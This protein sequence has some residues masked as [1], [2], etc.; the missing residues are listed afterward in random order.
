MSWSHPFPI[1]HIFLG[2]FIYLI[3]PF[4]KEIS[5]L[6]FLSRL[7]IV[8]LWL[9]F[10]LAFR[11][12]SSHLFNFIHIKPFICP[13]YWFLKTL[14]SII[15]N[16]LE[17]FLWEIK[18][19][20]CTSEVLAQEKYFDRTQNGKE[21]YGKKKN[22]YYQCS[23]KESKRPLKPSFSQTRA[24]Y[25]KLL[26]FFWDFAVGELPLVYFGFLDDFLWIS[27]FD[28][29]LFKPKF[30]FFEHVIFNWVFDFFTGLIVKV[31]FLDN[32]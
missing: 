8:S 27:D 2:I 16:H 23:K 4:I 30:N 13:S 11:T 10:W 20:R 7:F 5:T 26:F 19:L 31:R 24:A 29:F 9:L 1:I 21:K 17:L 25:W 32:D 15:S 6:L 12:T 14:K 3:F 22:K 28:I 18:I